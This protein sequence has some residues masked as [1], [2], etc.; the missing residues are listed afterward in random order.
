MQPQKANEIGIY[1]DRQW[2]CL[3]LSSALIDALPSEILHQQILQPDFAVQSARTDPH[4]QFYG[5]DDAIESMVE[6][7]DQQTNA[8]AFTLCATSMKQLFDV[9]DANDIMP[10]KSTWFT[11]KLLDGMIAYAYE[12]Q[13]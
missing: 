9:A 3:S 6:R 7:V 12:D 11:P 10:P 1:V 5:G 4:L 8:I 2:Y 13:A